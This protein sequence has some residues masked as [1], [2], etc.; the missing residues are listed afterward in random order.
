MELGERE[1]DTAETEPEKEIR[2]SRSVAWSTDGK[3]EERVAS[4]RSVDWS[5]S[6]V[7][8]SS[9]DGG[10]DWMD[11]IDWVSGAVGDSLGFL[12]EMKASITLIG[13]GS[14]AVW[15]ERYGVFTRAAL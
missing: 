7:S 15:S 8:S 12:R 2:R 14:R 5:S 6:S 9:L 13:G 10:L 11:G 4:L 1:W 3:R